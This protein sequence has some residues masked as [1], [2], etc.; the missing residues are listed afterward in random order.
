[1]CRD[2]QRRF[3]REVGLI[4]DFVVFGLVIAFEAVNLVNE[5]A[6]SCGPK[7]ASDELV[8]GLSGLFV[9]VGLDEEIELL[10]I[11]RDRLL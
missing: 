11:Y 4:V 7:L 5:D 1:M 8:E 3:L 6:S 10:P 2:D 9:R